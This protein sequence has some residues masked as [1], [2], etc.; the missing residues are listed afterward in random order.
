MLATAGTILGVFANFLMIQNQ[1]RLGVP[2]LFPYGVAVGVLAVLFIITEL[3]LIGQ[4]RLLPS[5][6]MLLSFILLVLFITGA[7]GTAIL[8]FGPDGNIN[9]R[10][11]DIVDN[12]KVFGP[13]LETLAWLQNNS[14][15]A[16]WKAAFAFWIIGA[17]FLIWMM[18]MASQVNND[19]FES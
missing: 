17:V 13:T 18:F 1:M 11:N 3:I 5:L 6:M 8:F 15:C 16:C 10:C 12:Q 19:Q 7:I 14:I 9:S 2:W 4:R